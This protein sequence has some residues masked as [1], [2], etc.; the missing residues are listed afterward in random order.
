MPGVLE[1][2]AYDGKVVMKLKMLLLVDVSR[3]V[4]SCFDLI[5]ALFVEIVNRYKLVLAVFQQTI[6]VTLH[7]ILIFSIKIQL[8][9]DMVPLVIIYCNFFNENLIENAELPVV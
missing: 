2:L 4:L 3:P 5:N 8:M 1:S 9:I 6:K 7:Y